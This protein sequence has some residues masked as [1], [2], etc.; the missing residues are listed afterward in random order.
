MD[1][2]IYII[3][4]A[5]LLLDFNCMSTYLGFL[6]QE[7]RESRS[8]YVRINI[9][10]PLDLFAHGPLE[11]EKKIKQINLINRWNPNKCYQSWSN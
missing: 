9:F 5:V 4:I 3:I 2:I 6:F 11:Y 10:I 1:N 7:V 8:L